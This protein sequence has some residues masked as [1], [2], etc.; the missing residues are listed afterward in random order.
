MAII[1]LDEKAGNTLLYDFIDDSGSIQSFTLNANITHSSEEDN[2]TTYRQLLY[3][4]T[5][6]DT[7]LEYDYTTVTDPAPDKQITAIRLLN[8]N[9]ELLQIKITDGPGDGQLA[10]DS[11]DA[12]LRC[13][14]AAIVDHPLPLVLPGRRLINRYFIHPATFLHQVAAGVAEVGDREMTVINDREQQGRA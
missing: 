6:L 2:G 10:V 12:V 11:L 3:V 14:P 9:D 1:K 7:V 5:A 4:D 8:G 13:H